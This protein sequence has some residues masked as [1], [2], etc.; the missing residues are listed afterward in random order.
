MTAVFRNYFCLFLMLAFMIVPGG[1]SAQEIYMDDGGLLGS[2]WGYALDGYDAVGYYGLEQGAPP[3]K[4]NAKFATIY[5]DVTWIFSSQENLDAF[6]A[7]PARYSPEYG[8]YCAW[9][10]ARGKLAK[11][12]PEV[13]YVYEGKLYLNI[14]ARYQRKWLANIDDDI[15]RANANWPAILSRP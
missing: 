14:T 12:N 7:D 3:V 2:P 10:M 15:A 8:N 4:G 9:A 11:G 6:T 5:K 13:W 1:A